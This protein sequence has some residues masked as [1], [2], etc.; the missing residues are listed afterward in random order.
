[1][2]TAPRIPDIAPNAGPNFLPYLSQ[3][4]EPPFGF[5]NFYIIVSDDE[6]GY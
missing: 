4:G 2:L 6:Y 1:M 5:P 3:G